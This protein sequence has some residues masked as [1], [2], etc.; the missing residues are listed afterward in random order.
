MLIAGFQPWIPGSIQ[1]LRPCET[2][3]GN[4]LCICSDL[5]QLKKLASN[6]T[7]NFQHPQSLNAAL[8]CSV[9]SNNPRRT[10]AVELLVRRGADLC[11]LNQLKLSPLHLSVVKQHYDATEVAYRLAWYPPANRAPYPMLRC[12]CK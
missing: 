3:I 11:T 8:H 12:T 9:Q 6:D 4:C 1:M 10:Q 2:Q 7:I 5:F